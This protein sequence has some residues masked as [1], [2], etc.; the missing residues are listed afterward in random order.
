MNCGD[1]IKRELKCVDEIKKS[2]EP[3]SKNRNDA[4][5]SRTDQNGLW[6]KFNGTKGVIICNRIKS[7]FPYLVQ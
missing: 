4:E 3:L 2:G 6:Y 1:E 5:L 7:N